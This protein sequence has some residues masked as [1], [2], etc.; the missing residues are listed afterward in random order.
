MTRAGRIVPA[1]CVDVHALAIKSDLGD[2]RAL[3]Q[4]GTAVPRGG[5]QPERRTIRIER[6]TLTSANGSGRGKARLLG[7]HAW[8]EHGASSPAATRVFR[9][10][11]RWTA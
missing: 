5:R 11:L 6:G 10:R 7:D 3:E 4:L 9:S 8:L 1:G 2:W